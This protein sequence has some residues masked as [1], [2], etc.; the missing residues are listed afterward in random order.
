MRRAENTPAPT[1]LTRRLPR[2]TPAPTEQVAPFFGAADCASAG[3]AWQRR[4]QR[5]SDSVSSTPPVNP[6]VT[7]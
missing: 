3:S 1:P 5:S 7:L 2:R 4:A 6:T